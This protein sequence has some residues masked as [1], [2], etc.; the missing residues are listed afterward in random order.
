MG[1]KHLFGLELLA[2]SHWLIKNEKP[3]NIEEVYGLFTTW[4][5]RKSKF[6]KA[7][8]NKACSTLIEK[9]WVDVIQKSN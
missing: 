9:G 8:V 2:T 5:K 6:T 1:L 4:N 7:H 3:K